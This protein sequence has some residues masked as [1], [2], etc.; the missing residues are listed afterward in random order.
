MTLDKI[1][2]IYVDNKQIAKNQISQYINESLIESRMFPYSGLGI[3][4]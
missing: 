1:K 2:K 4:F 3:P